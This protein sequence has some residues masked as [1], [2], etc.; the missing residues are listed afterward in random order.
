MNKREAAIA[1]ADYIMDVGRDAFNGHA[2]SPEMS[3][4][5][6]ERL[7]VKAGELYTFP[8]PELGPEVI[9]MGAMSAFLGAFRIAPPRIVEEAQDDVEKGRDFLVLV[10]AAQLIPMAELAGATPR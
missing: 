6:R 2:S 8:D 9:V 7:I 3:D 10:T 4:E 5:E 1:L